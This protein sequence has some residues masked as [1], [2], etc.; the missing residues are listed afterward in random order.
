MVVGLALR[1]V[2]VGFRSG[3][4]KFEE[5]EKSGCGGFL[6]GRFGSAEE[7][8]LGGGGGRFSTF[9]CGGCVLWLGRGFF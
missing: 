5:K 3:E 9:W 2:G 1:V 7:V 4:G 8:D 6:V